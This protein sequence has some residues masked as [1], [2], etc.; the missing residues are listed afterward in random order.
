M[1]RILVCSNAT[2]QRNG[3]TGVIMNLYRHL[4]H[5]RF[6]CDF[7]TRFVC[8]PAY[9]KEIEINGDNIYVLDRSLKNLTNYI[10]QVKKI[11]NNGYDI[12][13]IHGS[14]STLLLE[15][16]ATSSI[17]VK[18]THSHSSS[19]NSRIL[20]YLLRP[21]VN[22]LTDY[23]IACGEKAGKWM[24]GAN[25]YT[26]I[27]NGVDTKFFQY[28]KLNRDKIRS[29]YN[30]NNIVYGHIGNF[31][32]VKNQTF[33]VD[34][35]YE[36]C[37]KQKDAKLILIGDGPLK[38]IIKEKVK[39]LGISNKVIFTG[40]INNVHEF[41]SAIDVILMPSLF[42][43][44]PLSLIEEQVSGLPCLV[45]DVITTSCNITGMVHYC[46]LKKAPVEWADKAILLSATSNRDLISQR[47]IQLI[48]NVGY[49]AE[50]SARLL[51]SMYDRI[52][53]NNV[54]GKC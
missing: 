24:Y 26:V 29:E 42:E 34:V 48:G 18:I 10:R 33:V 27:N 4:D 3:Q 1:K 43:G 39:N 38:N 5:T 51:M 50:E 31:A 52:L 47:N 49:S 21:F 11:V 13:H 17:D 41:L 8:D 2:F 25:K 7:I 19:S 53:N 12:V 36:I 9:R 23:R 28:N 30:I 6:K 40:A 20:H 15:L 54:Y 32:E 16:L 22:V 37:R 14:S 44:F 46:P 35:F 45:S